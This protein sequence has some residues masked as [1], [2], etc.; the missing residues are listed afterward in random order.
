MA[1]VTN[2]EQFKEYCLKNK[3]S[4][5]YFSIIDKAI[6]RRWT[7][8]TSPVYTE[9]HHIVPNSISKNNDTVYLTAREHFICHLLLPKMLVGN[10][11]RKMMLALHRLIFGNKHINVIYVKNSNIYQKV[12]SKCSQYLSERNKVFWN[13]LTPEQRSA[14]Q[15]GKNNSMYGKKQK[16]STKALISQKAKE[17]LKDKTRHPLYDIG[18]SEETKKRMSENRKSY[19]D[20]KLWY[21]SVLENK[22]VFTVNPPS[23]YIKGRLP[24]RAKPPSCLGKKW[25]HNPI[26]QTTKYFFEGQQPAGFVL[27]RG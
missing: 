6:S 3:Y 20:G 1:T 10:D 22:E 2:R 25:Y 8:K 18:H 24:G 27:G 21:H 26:T 14:M 12:K 19:N 15:A 7:K 9:S 16:E 5:W 13:S 4:N 23:Y 17:R 11:K